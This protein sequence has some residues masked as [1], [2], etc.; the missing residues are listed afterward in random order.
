MQNKST[1]DGEP[2]V[3]EALNRNPQWK[4]M[5][6][7]ED[8]TGSMLPYVADL[9]VWNALGVNAKKVRHVV[10]FNDVD[11]KKT[12][13]KVVG[14]TGGIY[15]VNS[16]KIEDLEETMIRAM[17]AGNGGDTPE[18]DIEC[19]AARSGTNRS[20]KKA[21]ACSPLRRDVRA[22]SGAS[23]YRVENQGFAAYH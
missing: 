5:L 7:V 17:A 18:N 4:N 19:H 21:R 3:S 20:D 11:G 16:G 9:L 2:I 14:K 22:Q 23:L 13:D 8:V 15:H 6:V 12:S 1:D 10:L